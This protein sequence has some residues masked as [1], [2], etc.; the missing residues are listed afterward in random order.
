MF[1]VDLMIALIK[2]LC[3]GLG[4][5]PNEVNNPGMAGEGV[6]ADVD[7]TNCMTQTKI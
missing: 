4:K 6:V 5:D 1:K 7:Q 3:V 2:A